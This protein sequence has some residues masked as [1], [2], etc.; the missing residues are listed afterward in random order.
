MLYRHYYSNK[1]GPAMPI[2]SV[3]ILAGIIF[4]FIVFA[5]VL[6]WGE[7]QTRHIGRTSRQHFATSAQVHSLKKAAEDADCRGPAQK[8]AAHLG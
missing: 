7:Y 5:V 3:V 4:A 6:A 1:G 2:T 8:K